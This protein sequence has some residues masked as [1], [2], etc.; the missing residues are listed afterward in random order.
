MRGA[1]YTLMKRIDFWPRIARECSLFVGFLGAE[2]AGRL[3]EKWVALAPFSS[4]EVVPLHAKQWDLYCDKGMHLVR[5]ID[6]RRLGHNDGMR[7][8]QR[9]PCCFLLFRQRRFIA[10]GYHVGAVS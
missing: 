5:V 7:R 9:V 3:S 2:S 1:A 6:S 4:V 10:S 8:D